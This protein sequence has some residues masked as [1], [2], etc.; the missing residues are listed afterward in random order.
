[1]LQH[2]ADG[3]V[4]LMMGRGNTGP[5]YPWFGKDIRDGIPLAVENY[6]P[7]APAVARGRRR[8]AGQVPHAAAGLH[9]DARARSTASPPFVWHGSI[10]SP[11]DRRA[12]RL[13]RRRLLPQPHLL[14]GGAHRAD[15]RA[16]PPPVRALRPRRRRP[17]HRRPRRAGLHAE[18]QPGRGARVPALLRQRPGLRPRPVAGGVHRADPADR[19]QPAAG[20]RAHARLPRL[21]RRLPAPAVPHRP[22]RP[23]AQDRARAARH[24]R[25][26]GRAGAAQGV[27]RAQ[28]RPHVPDA[29]DPR[30]ACVAAGPA[31][32]SADR[33]PP[34]EVASTDEHRR[35]SP[36]SRAGA[37]RP[38]VH[39]AARRPARRGDRRRPL[40]ARGESVDVEVVELR[41][42][43]PRPGRP[44]CSPASR[45][46]AASC[47]RHGRRAP[48]A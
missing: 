42:R 19:R 30:V 11:R 3:R 5:V 29:P 31:S 35:T 10:R 15:G 1:M 13:L 2:L 12:G 18:E 43:R 16:L 32:R 7:A 20:H 34:Q 24:A 8:L 47:A 41:E 6:A 23:A 26:G 9:L 14:A 27:R 40:R 21:R 4:D 45:R 36:S 48:T 37:D 44:T 25:R 38:V 28:A 33:A 22:R 46:R 39:P 17:G